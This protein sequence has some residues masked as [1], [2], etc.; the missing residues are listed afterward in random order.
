MYDRSEQK[1]RMKQLLDQKNAQ[2]I[3]L[4]HSTENIQLFMSLQQYL[5]KK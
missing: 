4:F 3:V 2:N 1:I 5:Q